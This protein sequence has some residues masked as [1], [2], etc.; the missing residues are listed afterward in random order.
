MNE[1]LCFQRIEGLTSKDTSFVRL[2]IN[3]NN[4]SGNFMYLPYEKDSR[5]GTINGSKQKNIIKGIW[6]Y[7]QEGMQ[8]TL[9]V[10]FQLDGN[11]LMQK[12]YHVDPK[13]G[14][15]FLGADS[16]FD[17]EFKKIECD[18]IPEYPRKKD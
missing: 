6:T 11:T 3:K 2:I 1:T 9:S 17:L 14:R 4:V 16:P 5:V 8:D 13:T 7:M 18:V 10:E 12:S 15:Q